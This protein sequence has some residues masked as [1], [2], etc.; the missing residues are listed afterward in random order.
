MMKAC[1]LIATLC[2][3]ACGGSEQSSP[4]RGNSAKSA[5]PPPA[6]EHVAPPAQVAVRI[7]TLRDSEGKIF[8]A[9]Y[10]RLIAFTRAGN[11]AVVDGAKKQ[12]LLFDTSGRETHRVGLAGLDA[13]HPASPTMMFLLPGDSIAVWD[14]QSRR[15]SIFDASLRLERFERFRLWESLDRESSPVGRLADGRW[16]WRVV[17]L[18]MNPF[19][20]SDVQTVVDKPSL[21]VG[22]SHQAPTNFYVLRSRRGVR[23]TAKTGPLSTS[24]RT[25]WPSYLQVRMAAVCERGVV[26]LDPDSIRTLDRNGRAVSVRP[27]PR[28]DTLRTPAER[29]KMVEWQMYGDFGDSTLARKM[30]SALRK[31]VDTLKVQGQRPRIDSY[32]RLWYV[33]PDTTR[34]PSFVID[35]V[36]SSGQPDAALLQERQGALVHMGDNSVAMFWQRPDTSLVMTLTRFSEPFTRAADSPLGRCS[37]SFVY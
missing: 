23:V 36:D 6:V 28:T 19:W 2:V 18:R 17:S 12:L 20:R 13:Y 11:T 34:L 31:I 35:R 5:P 25:V 33:R 24:W 4:A 1:G 30:R 7:D 14:Y 3:L 22:R 27:L 8:S 21:M 9:Q 26:I 10:G 37:A 29:A 15:L 16:I 32:G